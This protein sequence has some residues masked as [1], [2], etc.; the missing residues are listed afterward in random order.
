V[1]A[2][3]CTCAWEWGRSP[4][5]TTRTHSHTHS[6][7][8]LPPLQA[9]PLTADE[10]A[11]LQDRVFGADCFSSTQV[12]PS[13]I[14]TFFKG[15][16]RRSAPN[17]SATVQASGQ[18]SQTHIHS[19]TSFTATHS[20]PNTIHGRTSFTAAH[21][22]QPHIIHSRTSFT[23]AHH[24]QPHNHRRALPFTRAHADRHRRTRTAARSLKQPCIHPHP[25][26]LPRPPPHLHP[27]LHPASFP[28]D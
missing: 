19:R 8:L 14:G 17:A 10:T 5:R 22:S 26:L 11:L 4:G 28:P 15:N 9:A 18:R 16:L 6:L 20:Q 12:Q 24:S 25:N 13:P 27:H 2:S 23:A 3:V 21:H 7:I 1:R